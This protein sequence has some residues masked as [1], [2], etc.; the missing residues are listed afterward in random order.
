MSTA[1]KK[2]KSLT[3]SKHLL[4]E[5]DG[6]SCFFYRLA[7]PESSFRFSVPSYGKKKQ[8]NF[9]VTPIFSCF[10]LW[11][12][13]FHLKKTLYHALRRFISDE[14]LLLVWETLYPLI[15]NNKLA[16]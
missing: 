16:G 15:L 11:P 1:E 14:L 2:K 10:K 6:A 3:F 4:H 5:E 8:T 12:F 9:F 7:W 13:F